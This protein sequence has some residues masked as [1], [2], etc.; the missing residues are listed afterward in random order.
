[1]C[2][3][4][5]PLFRRIYFVL[6]EIIEQLVTIN[7]GFCIEHYISQIKDSSTNPWFRSHIYNRFFQ[8]TDHCLLKLI[9]PYATE[10]KES[11]FVMLNEMID[12]PSVTL[13]SSLHPFFGNHLYLLNRFEF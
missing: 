3:K 9:D 8:I 4:E 13:L 6:R 7:A 2:Q 1:M 10:A 5:I 12:G 11:C